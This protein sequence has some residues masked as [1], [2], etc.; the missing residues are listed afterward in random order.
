MVDEYLLY[1]IGGTNIAKKDMSID[2]CQF[3]LDE[4]EQK[5]IIPVAS[6]AP[7]GIALVHNNDPKELAKLELLRNEKGTLMKTLLAPEDHVWIMSNIQDL[8][9]YTSS[10]PY[11][12]CAVFQLYYSGYDPSKGRILR[13]WKA[14]EDV[15]DMS[16]SRCGTTDP[17]SSS[18]IASP[19]QP[20]LF[21][22]APKS[23]GLPNRCHEAFH[24]VIEEMLPMRKRPKID[25]SSLTRTS[26]TIINDGPYV[27]SR[28]V[29]ASSALYKIK[30]NQAESRAKMCRR[31]LPVDIPQE[32]GKLTATD[33]QFYQLRGTS[34]DHKATQTATA[35]KNEY[36]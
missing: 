29:I 14:T 18:I 9:V 35:G 20:E 10:S 36:E 32:V 3:V 11:V 8:Y 1:T 2:E 16:L 24:F 19:F 5:G 17:S 27:E 12:G 23:P 15:M 28:G 7:V 25:V 26:C 33:S 21:F 30:Q 6:G 22:M 4:K 13:D 31:E 34:S